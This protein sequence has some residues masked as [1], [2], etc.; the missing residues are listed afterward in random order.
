[1]IMR[2]TK[3]IV[4]AVALLVSISSAAKPQLEFTVSDRAHV[5][6]YPWYGNEKVDGKIIGWKHS[7][8]S[9]M[10]FEPKLGSYSSNDPNI[11][12]AHMRMIKRAGIGV[13]CLSWWGI[14]HYTDNSNYK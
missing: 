7:D 14:D 6:Y 4:I 8:E 2:F 12:D 9:G 1:M 11:I 10:T 13:V 5:F 3:E